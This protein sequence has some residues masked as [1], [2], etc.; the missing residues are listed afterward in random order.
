MFV[1]SAPP[2]R[3]NNNIPI[4]A[5]FLLTCRCR[6]DDVLVNRKSKKIMRPH[7]SAVNHSR[8][9]SIAIGALLVTLVWIV[10][11]QT[12]GHGFINFDDNKY[13]YENAQVSRGLSFQGAVWAFTHVH[14]ENWHPLT[15]ITHML[16]CQ[17]YGLSAGG[18][19]FTNVLLHS[20][21]VVLLFLVLQEMTSSRWRSAL[22]AALFA[23]HPLRVESVAWIAERKDGLSGVFFML[24][25]LTYVRYTRAPTVSRYVL[26]S[27]LFACGLMSKPMLVTLPLVLLLLDYWPLDRRQ[28]SEVR[29]RKPEEGFKR[30]SR[31]N[32]ILEKIPLFALSAA[33]CAVTM[34]AQ[35]PTISSLAGLPLPWRASNAIASVVTYVVQLIWPANLAVFYPH[36]RGGQ[37]G[38]LVSSAALAIAAIT[39]LAVVLRKRRPYILVGWLWYVGMLLPVLGLVQVGLQGHA[40]RYTYLPHIGIL[41][42]FSWGVADLTKRWRQRE[43][44][45]Q[46]SAAT[47]IVIMTACSY[48]QVTYWRDSISLW[49]HTLAVTTNNDTAHLCMAEA[50][51]QRGRLDEAIAHSQAASEIR[52]ENAGAY[53][54]VP[55]VLTDKQAQ[56][57]V[58]YWEKRLK[59]ND[60]DTDAHN[61]LGVVLVQSGD[62][63][64]AIA[65]WEASLAIKPDDGNA[66]NNLAW[67]LATSPDP[68]IRNGN[69]AVELA[70]KTA[71][72][73]GG[74]DPIVLRTL[75]A[76]YAEAGKFSK[77]IEIAEHASEMALARQ[78]RSLAE[79]LQNEISL[80]RSN[81]PHR[82]IPKR[83]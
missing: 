2:T 35:R 63:R 6:F 80:Y 27:I 7:T 5:K 66:Q 32:L 69:R 14:S 42:G 33:S 34:L 17:V 18:H 46:G 8:R 71:A 49:A 15:T 19:H 43:L 50:L 11:A 9:T 65:Q 59:D 48:R 37:S 83:Q 10:F 13:I 64:G 20:I 1:L 67:V 4:A 16:D 45:L 26:L 54:R 76:A 58:A 70:E 62:P 44:I 22:V 30:Q 73:P 40:D 75:A 53:G 31:P 25:L 77:A 82:E 79:T 21:A 57:A 51:L 29:D 68:T 28:R 12:L 47:V 38:W 56:S 39:V 72:L 41:I 3:D 78:N 36:P 52:P 23:I 81:T 60:L 55:V 61:N 74:Q 24:T